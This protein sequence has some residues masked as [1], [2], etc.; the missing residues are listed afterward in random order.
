MRRFESGTR[1]ADGAGQGRDG[2][3]LRDDALVQF[4]FNAQQLLGFFFLNGGDRDAGPAADDLF[5]VLAGDD[6][7]GRVIEVVFVAQGAQ[8]L[9]LLAFFVGVEAGLLKL[10]VGDG[11]VHAVDDELD[12]LVDFGDFFGQGSL[13]QLDA[14]TCLVNQVNGLVGQEA[15]RDVAV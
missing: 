4:F 6:A 13:P 15:I 12:P 8:V 14:R 10:V 5:D 2:L 1:A 7:G 3:V 11:R 9:A